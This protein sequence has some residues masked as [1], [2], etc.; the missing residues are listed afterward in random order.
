[1][2]RVRITDATFSSP[3]RNRLVCRELLAHWEA[4]TRMESAWTPP[5][6]TS[7]AI[8]ANRITPAARVGPMCH[9]ADP[10]FLPGRRIR[11]A[12]PNT[13]QLVD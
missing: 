1:M 10:M 5:A 11:R 4:I 2:A 3:M 13:A 7:P 8:Q 9:R 12:L 6:M